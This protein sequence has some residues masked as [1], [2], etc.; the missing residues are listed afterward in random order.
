MISAPPTP[1]L[2]LITPQRPENSMY[3]SSSYMRS[4]RTLK[5][6]AATAEDESS[7]S[8]LQQHHHH[9]HHHHH[10]AGIVNEY[11]PGPGGTASI[12]YTSQHADTHWHHAS[13]GGH[14][15]SQYGEVSLFPPTIVSSQCFIAV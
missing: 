7:S 2:E 3:S 14:H 6:A 5:L 8:G 15:P 1:L 4:G 9:H 11:N 10:P 12:I 13:H